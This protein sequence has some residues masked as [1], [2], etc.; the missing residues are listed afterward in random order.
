M[1]AAIVGRGVIEGAPRR[2]LSTRS[3]S[4]DEEQQRGAAN[5]FF[6]VLLLEALAREWGARPKIWEFLALAR[7]FCV[8]MFLFCSGLHTRMLLWLANLQPS[9]ARQRPSPPCQSPLRRRAALRDAM[10]PMGRTRGGARRCRSR[11]SHGYRRAVKAARRRS[12][13][14]V[15]RLRALRIGGANRVR[16]RLAELRGATAVPDHGH[17]RLHTKGSHAHRFAPTFLR[18]LDQSL[19]RLRALS[20]R[21]RARAR[22]PLGLSKGLGGYS[23]SAPLSGSPNAP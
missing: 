4:A 23:R 21:A 17:H 13:R 20:V 12:R 3:R 5:S 2:R 7:A 19:S 6:M 18:P 16:R 9:D 1:E 10:S 15:E 14:A 22:A 11:C 8:T